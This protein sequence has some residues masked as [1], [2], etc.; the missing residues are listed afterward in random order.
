MKL[1]C[2]EIENYRAIEKLSLP[3]RPDLTVLHGPNGC[4]KTSVL[5]AIATG[6]GAISRLLPDVSGIDFRDSDM[7]GARPLRVTLKT[8]DGMEWDRRR[9][10]P[11]RTTANRK[12]KETIEAIVAADH[13]NAEPRDL[14]VA[15]FYDA[16]RAVTGRYRYG[17][18]ETKFPRYAA[19]SPKIDFGEFFK[20]F[21]D[22]ENKELRKLRSWTR[23]G[24]DYRLPELAAVRTA[25]ERMVPGVFNPRIEESPLRFEVSIKIEGRKP[26][27]LTLDRLSGGYRTALALAGD[28]ARRMVQGN[29][30]L[31]EP[32]ESEAIVLIDEVDLHLH[33]E[34]QQH[35]LVDLTRTF[36]NAQFIVSTHSP[37]VLTTARPEQ[38]VELRREGGLIAAGR[39]SAP[40]YGA[41]AGSVLEAVMGVRERPK[42]NE[43]TEI[44]KEYMELIDDDKGECEKAKILRRKLEELSPDDYGLDRA[45]I[46]LRRRK[47]LKR[48]RKSR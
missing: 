20:W 27:N 35:I 34:W 19:L 8:R 43:F 41:E 33:P 22:R 11:A 3:L 44:Y 46:E 47:A 7:R 39:S 28:I 42:G 29:P 21:Y 31:D 40:T 25:V 14:P 2:V 9:R 1:E 13:D 48:M 32:L 17:D 24:A 18:P 12:L 38:I 45:D 16:D 6:L 30:H 10:G 37:Q 5:A 15:V 4:G 23:G 36:P 26:E